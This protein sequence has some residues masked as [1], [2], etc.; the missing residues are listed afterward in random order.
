MKWFAPGFKR[1]MEI[2]ST[3]LKNGTSF[4][5]MPILCEKDIDNNALGA[6]QYEPRIYLD[7][8]STNSPGSAR[9]IPLGNQRVSEGGFKPT[10]PNGCISAH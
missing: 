8:D 6:T 3:L 7:L 9:W 5:Y 2:E 10:N 4:Q 1:Q